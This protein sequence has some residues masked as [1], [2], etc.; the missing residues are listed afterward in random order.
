[1][2]VL[3]Q[4]KVIRQ[5]PGPGLLHAFVFW[6]FL[7][8]AV[9][10]LDLIVRLAGGGGFLLALPGDDAGQAKAAAIYE[11]TATAGL[12]PTWRGDDRLLTAA[13]HP[14]CKACPR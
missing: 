11:V 10:T 6:G 5:R 13:W 12:V 14:R 1:M 4:G 2:E 9:S 7:A 8:F 3:L